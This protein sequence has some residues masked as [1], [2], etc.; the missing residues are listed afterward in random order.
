MSAALYQT[1]GLRW[2]SEQEI[3]HRT[4]TTKVLHDTIQDAL[5]V[6]NNAWWF[7]RVEAPMIMPRS[8]IA[9]GYGDDDIWT[10]EAPLMGDGCALRPETT[11]GSY[12]LARREM[13][14]GRIKP[15]LCVWQVGKSFRRETN[16][17][18]SASK[19]R[20]YEFTQAEWQCIYGADTKADYR[21][22]ILPQVQR[23][24]SWLSGSEARIVPS[25]RVP[26]YSMR[27][28]DIEVLRPNGKWTEVCS[29]S[30]RTDFSDEHLVLEIAVGLDRV[31]E[32]AGES[33]VLS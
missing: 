12:M 13:K 16:D 9:P 17:G 15:P 28:D 27:T 18:A 33:G 22:A 25:D 1:G 30:T 19:L 5:V 21:A 31:V 8:A 23:K 4:L 6:V 32:I 10:L 26:D 2:W 7:G 3:D 14:A 11:A 29:V 24:L 20:F